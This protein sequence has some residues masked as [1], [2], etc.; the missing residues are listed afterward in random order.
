MNKKNW[1]NISQDA[2]T[3]I[4]LVHAHFEGYAYDPHM[5][6]SYLIGVTEFGRQQFN[7]R[8]KEIN[9]YKDHVFM[10]EPEELHDG[11]APDPLGFTYKMLH[12]DPQWLKQSY[13]DL[14]SNPFELSI[15]STLLSDP[16]LAKHIHLTYDILNSQESQLLK[17]S[18]LDLLLEK[19][20]DKKYLY[21]RENSIQALPNIAFKLKSILHD[22]IHE[23]LNLKTLADL[24]EVD[25]FF[26]H[27]VFKQ[28]FNC[29]PHQYLIQLRLN[30]AKELLK[31]GLSASNVASYLCF[32]DQSHL[33]RWF[34][35]C[36]G[37]TLHQYQKACTNILDLK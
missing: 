10:L 25:R 34:K 15:Q 9:S 1:V 27:R 8:K 4:E 3:G 26:I 22:H 18:N 11:N 36:Y 33:G 19:L 2:F 21:H 31:K 32:S 14:F 20:V 17:D 28:N 24:V 23:E 35:R 5:H 16:Q 13:E 29:S 12:I 6:S 37:I 7:C 30:K